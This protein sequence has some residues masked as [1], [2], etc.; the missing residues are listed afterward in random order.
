MSVPID[1]VIATRNAGKVRELR[2]LMRV[3]GIRWRSLD[4]FSTHPA[5]REIGKTFFDNAAKKAIET[6]RRIGCLALAD[7]SGLEV[8]ALSGAPGIHSARYAGH[9]GDDEANNAKLL[10]ALRDVPTS[11]RRAGFRCVLVLADA[12]RVLASTEGIIRGRIAHEPAGSGG[13]GYDCLFF[14]PLLK[15]TSA[16]LSARAKN[17]ISHRAE[18]ARRMQRRLRAAMRANGFLATARAGGQTARPG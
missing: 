14:I 10:R 6:A 2:A 15:K 12:S 5:V 16:Q 18:A 4:E 8:D 11:R 1:I 7:D 17:Q 13:F 3:P 9:Q